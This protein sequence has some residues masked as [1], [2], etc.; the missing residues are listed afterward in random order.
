MKRYFPLGSLFTAMVLAVLLATVPG[1]PDKTK[2][3]GKVAK[4]EEKKKEGGDTS[5]KKG[6]P[7]VVKNTDAVVK[8]R[9]IYDGDPPAAKKIEMKNHADAPACHAGPDHDQTWVLGKEKGVAAVVVS[10]VP[11]DGKFFALDGKQAKEYKGTAWIDQPF[12]VYEPHV[13]ALFAAYKTEDGKLHETGEKLMVKNSGKISHNTKVSGDSRKNPSTGKNIPPETKEG[14]PFDI[15]YQK[16]PIDIACD[17]HNWMNAKLITFDH[18]F[19]AVTNKDGQF[20]IK[21]V[22]SGVEFTIK[23]WHPQAAPASEKKTFTK[24]DNEVPTLKIKA[25]S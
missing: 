11:V 9:V 19:F 6:D 8:G 25:S 3:D 22:P 24:G 23:T 4:E 12:C 10:L 20:E 5:G 15:T 18:P 14:M 7:L 1:C 17:K 2:K 13:V 16:E 21:N